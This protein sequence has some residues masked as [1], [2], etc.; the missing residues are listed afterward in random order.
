MTMHQVLYGQTPEYLKVAYSFNRSPARRI[1]SV[2]VQLHQ[3]RALNQDYGLI[4]VWWSFQWLVPTSGIVY[5]RSSERTHHWLRLNEIS[6]DIC[7]VINR[8]SNFCH[9]LL[10]CK[11]QPNNSSVTCTIKFTLRI[12]NSHG[13]G[14]LRRRWII[15]SI[16]IIIA[17]L[18]PY[19]LDM[20]IFILVNGPFLSW[21]M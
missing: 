8:M 10:Y 5:Q 3:P 4:L 2:S 15:I 1:G 21:D 9:W 20:V 7:S 18:S 17:L 6:S 12:Q 19:G 13:W 14:K 11:L 16:I